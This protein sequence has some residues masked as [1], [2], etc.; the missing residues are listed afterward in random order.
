[1]PAAFRT[2]GIGETHGLTYPPLCYWRGWR[3]HTHR[4][5]MLSCCWCAPGVGG[6]LG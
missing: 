1:M 4:R 5:L 6:G 3:P 2:T